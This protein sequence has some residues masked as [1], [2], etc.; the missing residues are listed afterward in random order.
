MATVKISALT[1]A[2]ALAGTEIVPI[3]QANSTVRTTAQAIANLAAGTSVTSAEVQTASAAATSVDTRVNALSQVVSII[4]NVLSNELSVRAAS[5]QTA[6]AAATSVDGRVNSVNAF[7]SGISARSVGNVSTHG[8]QSVID[9]LSG[10]IS[11]EISARGASIQT[12]SA[13][14]TSVDTRVNTV[15]NLVSVLSDR[16]TSISAQIV[17]VDTHA[18][19]ASAAATSV[20]G[21]VNSVNTFVS[22]ISARSVGNVSTHGFQSVID[23]LSSRISAVTGNSVTSAEV[24]TASAAATSADAHAATASLAA[25]SADGHAATASLAATSVDGRVNSVN[26]F[27][28]GIS[29]RS[30]GGISTHGFQSVIDA[31]SSRISAV[32]GN[33]VT[34]AEVQTASA[35]ATSADA[36][37]N[38]A[39]AAATSVDARVNAISQQV[40]VLSQQASALSATGTWLSL[41]N[42]DASAV[43]AGAPVYVGASAANTFL[44]AD[45]DGTSA[46]R[47]VIGLV[48]DANIAAAGTG[49]V[50]TRGKLTLT[51]AEW[52][53]I[54]GQ[55]GGLTAGSKYYL[56]VTAGK[57]T[58][59]APATGVWRPV[60]IALSTTELFIQLS[61]V[62]DATSILNALSNNIS[63]AS[64]AATSADG[65]AAAA[66][67]AATSVDTRVNTV[68]N[69]VSVLS[70][71]V[72]SVSAQIVSVDG[73]I[74]SVNTTMS[75]LSVRSVGNISTHGLQ[76]VLDALSNRIS[77]GGGVGSVTS[78]EVQT[79][80]A[81]A[82]SADAHAA[83]ASLAA[84]SVDARVNT[85][86]NL[87]SVL[88]GEQDRGMISVAQSVSATTLTNLSGLS[89][90][91]SAGGIYNLDAMLLIDR[92]STDQPVRLGMTFS[93][94]T[95]IRGWI[96]LGQSAVRMFSGDSAS[97]SVLMSTISAGGTSVVAVFGGLLEA[98][99]SGVIQLQA[100]T[101]AAT[102]VH[103]YKRGSYIRVYKVGP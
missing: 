95:N 27:I 46:L 38:A 103:T 84:T 97:G 96:G 15:S 36:H 28:S 92:V 9:A 26:T 5:V 29:A 62:D 41:R 34:S 21:R 54:T 67:A 59:T 12:L 83:A 3:V 80:S 89:V 63:I 18:G 14:V 31:L 102:A 65:H 51:T 101:S 57:L 30:V 74:N 23:A 49:R 71:R 56:D 45:A 69:L 37:A 70:D 88:S 39:S 42:D 81:A 99:A 43:S 79:A 75:G 25:T 85:L 90:S 66:S 61:Q 55:V 32:T 91:V 17:S 87:V 64:A 82:T 11:N 73:R 100:A 60:G 19:T 22:G 53:S 13:A 40:S 7:V 10:V 24:Q 76:S 50:Q 2:G 86:S 20:D 52:D 98:S 58:T 6:S 78:A 93:A 44:R 47:Q 33:S 48:A 1:A 77:A 35:A 72:T 94:M 8:L 16:V 4:S 68:S